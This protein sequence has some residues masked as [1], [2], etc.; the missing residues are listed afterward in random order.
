MAQ[1]LS[2]LQKTIL[3]IGAEHRLN[4]TDNR[5]DVFRNEA[6]AAYYGVEA[7]EFVLRNVRGRASMSLKDRLGPKRATAAQVATTWAFERLEERGLLHNVTYTFGGRAA[8]LTEEGLET[9]AAFNG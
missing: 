7:P 4:P 3:R 6:L 1:G 5:A 9:A 8:N 2:D